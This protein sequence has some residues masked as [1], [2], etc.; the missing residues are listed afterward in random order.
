METV[1][2]PAQNFEH[3]LQHI[4]RTQRFFQSHVWGIPDTQLHDILCWMNQDRQ[5]QFLSG[6]ICAKWENVVE[7]N[8]VLRQI[9]WYQAYVEWIVQTRHFLNDVRFSHFYEG[10]GPFLRQGLAAFLKYS[11]SVQSLYL[12]NCLLDADTLSV[13]SECIVAFPLL[14]VQITADAVSDQVHQISKAYKQRPLQSL[15]ISGDRDREHRPCSPPLPFLGIY[16]YRS[17]FLTLHRTLTDLLMDTQLIELSLV[18]LE[19]GHGGNLGYGQI[20]KICQMLSTNKVLQTLDLSYNFLGTDASTLNSLAE[21]VQ[22]NRTLQH[23]K[24]TRNFLKGDRIG[25]LIEALRDNSTLQILD[26]AQ[27]GLTDLE[28]T[29]IAD[30]L[31]T[32]E[33]L[34]VLHL[35][36]NDFSNDGLLALAEALKINRSL[37]YVNLSGVILNKYDFQTQRFSSDCFNSD[38]E[39]IGALFALVEMIRVNNRLVYF[40]L[41]N[42]FFSQ[43]GYH[44]FD[45][46]QGVQLAM[47]L[48]VV[49][50]AIC[51]NTHLQYIGGTHLSQDRH[52]DNEPLRDML[53]SMDT[54]TWKF[55]PSLYGMENFL[56][57]DR[58]RSNTREHQRL[59]LLGLFEAQQQKHNNVEFQILSSYVFPMIEFPNSTVHFDLAKR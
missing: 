47:R 33:S 31:R 58:L 1:N 35:Q 57:R 45:E 22:T 20:A 6:D 18:S 34:C 3:Y 44:L 11:S 8:P 4:Y 54:R 40:N 25:R 5:F 17:D 46:V 56:I 15:Y 24:L 48:H 21:L 42:F 16:E 19:L 7:T 51:M 2:E 36:T 27:C 39:C 53:L 26:L 38:W 37:E 50:Q 30:V 13:L 23:L 41:G 55:D 29:K 9:D 32:N 59:V 12:A 52:Y 49:A 10:H 14:E 43:R 28:V